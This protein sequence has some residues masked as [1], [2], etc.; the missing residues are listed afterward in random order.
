M[1]SD[2]IILITAVLSLLIG[3]LKP[4]LR[5]RRLEIGMPRVIV[6]GVGHLN[7]LFVGTIANAAVAAGKKMSQKRRTRRDTRWR[8]VAPE[9]EVREVGAVGRRR[10]LVAGVLAWQGLKSAG[11]WP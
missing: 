3:A 2:L 1:A 8:W 10:G 11:V 9:L 6:C 7:H 4:V 5:I